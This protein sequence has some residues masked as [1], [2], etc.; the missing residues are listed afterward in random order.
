MES[1][2]TKGSCSHHNVGAVKVRLSYPGIVP[3]GQYK[4]GSIRRDLFKKLDCEQQI[5]FLNSLCN[6]GRQ[7]C[8]HVD[9]SASMYDQE[10]A[11]TVRFRKHQ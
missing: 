10:K 11:P 7:V 5:A 2:G 4:F 8:N 9:S 1:N 6:C 3:I